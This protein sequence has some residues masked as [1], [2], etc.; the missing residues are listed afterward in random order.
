M[1]VFAHECGCV[2]N[3]E[4]KSEGRGVC[5]R[6]S[7]LLVMILLLIIAQFSSMSV[8]AE[9][10]AE[11]GFEYEV[12]A[13]GDVTITDYIGTAKVVTIP[14]MLDGKKVTSI[15]D[16][17]FQNNELTSV[18][19]PNSVTSIGVAAFSQ[20]K[21]TSMT[22]PDSVTSIGIA[23]FLENELT[24]VTISNNVTSIG[25]YAFSQNKLTSVKIPNG[26]TSIG[27]RAFQNN[28][29]TSVTIPNSVT[30]IGNNAFQDNKLTSVKISDSVTSIADY[31]FMN[32]ELTSVKI[33]DNV[34]SIGMYAFRNNELTSVKIPDNVTSIGIYTFDKNK[35][36]S[37]TFEGTPTIELTSF[38]S[39]SEW[40]I[41]EDFNTRWNK[42]ITAPMTIY[43]KYMYTISFNTNGGSAITN[44]AIESN[45]TATEPTAPTKMGYTFAEWYKDEALTEKWDFATD[46]VTENTT[47]YAKWTVNSY[48]L[49]FNTN[50][51][52]A[53]ADQPIEYNKTATEPADP[54]KTGHT[55][56]GWY[57]EAAL[58][59][60]WNFA[61]DV[62]TENTTLY[63]KWTVNSYT[64]TFN[65]NGGSAVANQ[66]IEPNGKATEPTAP[67]KTGHTF[68]GW[69]KEADFTNKWGFMTD[70]VTADTIL[71]A[72]WTKNPSGG[73]GGLVPVPV[74]SYTLTFDE[75]G[76]SVVATQNLIY[77]EK[78]LNPTVPTKAGHTFAGWYKEAN[79]T[80]EWD[81]KTDVVKENTILY[82]KWTSNS[83]SCTANFTDTSS[84]WAKEEIDEIACRSIIKGYPDGTFKPNES[85][86]REHVAVMFTSTFELTPIRGTIKFND[87]PTNHMYYDAITQV[88]QAGIFEGVSNGKFNPDANMT[89]A[90]MAKVVVLAFRLESSETSTNV[91]RDV[92]STHWAKNY[93]STLADYG[94]AFGDNGD[95]KPEEP[96]TRAQFVSF[97]YRVLNS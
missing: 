30:S 87:V 58:A 18:T 64:L 3:G 93:I 79:F 53:V 5:M 55:F 24:S 49:S 50:G 74:Q 73:G 84:H 19:I 6:K 89:C 23:A 71:Y 25:T 41:D 61:T 66:A 11:D 38:D 26:V 40:Y 39:D 9:G 81:F 48:T 13:N 4:M 70:I 17:A 68:A 8:H 77:N 47:L 85:I 46:V 54:T 7:S 36:T 44:Q 45:E 14:E 76:G 37:V 83:S 32:N 59:T 2:A 69:Y 1:E 33:P 60:E 88:Y 21:L 96:V 42:D 43:A 12:N 80:N 75:N 34:T 95:F 57:K 63:A 15:G 94:I 35:L 51:G 65:T 91:F 92:P 31:T 27:S 86:K 97:M 52:S 29:L 20:N 16:N 78:A 62:V 22:I 10:V 90:Q 56:A 72:K 82:A 28:E 67:T